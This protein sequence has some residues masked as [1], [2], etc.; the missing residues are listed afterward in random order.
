[1]STTRLQ[2]HARR[3]RTSPPCPETDTL[4]VIQLIITGWSKS[5]RGGPGA[6][7]RNRVPEAELLL[8][9]EETI[10]EPAFVIH[11]A[12]HEF[13]Q[14]EVWSMFWS[15]RL[16]ESPC[17]VRSLAEP[18]SLG[19]F[20][21]R[22]HEERLHLDYTWLDDEGMPKRYSQQDLLSLS[23]GQWGRVRINARH[24]HFFTTL[25]WDSSEWWYEKWV[26]NVGLFSQR[27]ARVFLDTQPVKTVSMMEPLW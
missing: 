8:L 18:T 14:G 4:A 21:L 25:G 23:K 16:P 22:F 19:S 17:E 2:R 9:P 26:L 15:D 10:P 24:S 6:E 13:N 27:D 3:Q 5:Y 12:R 20:K 7:E 1:M 11:S